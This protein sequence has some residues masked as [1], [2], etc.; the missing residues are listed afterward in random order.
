MAIAVITWSVKNVTLAKKYCAPPAMPFS[1][2][3]Q[4]KKSSFFLSLSLSPSSPVSKDFNRFVATKD[5]ALK[6]FA[7]R[8]RERERERGGGTRCDER[9]YLSR[10]MTNLRKYIFSSRA[11]LVNFLSA[12][13]AA[14]S[15]QLLQSVY[16]TIQEEERGREREREEERNVNRK[17]IYW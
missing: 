2:I 8:E 7:T 12:K 15:L 14:S 4:G 1:L 3:D 10:R 13:T 9:V 17:N 6:S 11:F 16:Q 5:S